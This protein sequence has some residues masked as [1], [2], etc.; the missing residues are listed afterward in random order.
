MGG[1][2]ATFRIL[3]KSWKHMIVGRAPS[4][5]LFC[6]PCTE[7]SMMK[8]VSSLAIICGLVGAVAGCASAPPENIGVHFTPSQ[9]AQWSGESDSIING[10]AFIRVSDTT[11]WSILW[12]PFGD[13]H[14]GGISTCAGT[15]ITA[16]PA[17]AFFKSYLDKLEEDVVMQPLPEEMKALIHTTLC[18]K[19]G[20][21][22]FKGLAHATWILSTTTGW[23]ISDEKIGGWINKRITINGDEPM[24]VILT[25]EPF[26]D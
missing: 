3:G 14:E 2:K 23:T 15:T 21:F 1:L 24:K 9:Y 20:N 5:V 7:K 11:G 18:D 22:T 19:E 26:D 17:T 13:Q 8:V 25:G 4:P 10:E 16:M 12:G 6:L